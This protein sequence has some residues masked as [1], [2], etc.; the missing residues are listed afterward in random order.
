LVDIDATFD[1][2]RGY[3]ATAA[4]HSATDVLSEPRDSGT[5]QKS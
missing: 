2:R 3:R 1:A 4:L 5:F